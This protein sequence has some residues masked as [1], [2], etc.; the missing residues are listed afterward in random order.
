MSSSERPSSPTKTTA[1]MTV[2]VDEAPGEAPP[3]HCIVT[4]GSRHVRLKIST[5]DSIGSLVEL[6]KAKMH[7]K[8][9]YE[10]FGD[11]MVGVRSH[12]LDRGTPEGGSSSHHRLTLSSCIR[13]PPWRRNR[14][15]GPRGRCFG[16]QIVHCFLRRAI[17]AFNHYSVVFALC[18]DLPLPSCLHGNIPTDARPRSRAIACCACGRKRSECLP[19]QGRSQSPPCEPKDCLSP[20]PFAHRG[21]RSLFG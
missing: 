8:Y 19:T 12:R 10:Q 5:H 21:S 2:P 20:R 13:S 11:T 4:L 7:K 17:L 9:P 16:G 15:C 18:D 6:A 3:V 1:A 14:R